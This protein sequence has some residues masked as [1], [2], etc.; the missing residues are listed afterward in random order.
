[1][2]IQAAAKLEV[3]AIAGCDVSS[4]FLGLSCLTQPLMVVLA[5]CINSRDRAKVLKVEIC[6]LVQEKLSKLS[7]ILHICFIQSS[8]TLL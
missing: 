6:G 4:T 2:S 5:L 7:V 1:M 8:L 3:F